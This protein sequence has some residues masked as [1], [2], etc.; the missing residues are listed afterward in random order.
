MKTL[1]T[2]AA[3]LA[4]GFGATGAAL[5]QDSLRLGTSSSGSVP[6]TI[7]V[8]MSRVIN[9]NAGINV[10]IEPVGGSIANIFALMNDQV[11]MAI[12]TALAAVDG[13]QG[14]APLPRAVPVCLIAQGQPSFRQLLVRRSANIDSL[15]ALRGKVWINAMAPNPDILLISNAMM[16]FAGLTTS[17]FRAV[18]M[19]ESGEAISGFETGTI[20]AVTLPAS[21]GAPTVARLMENRTID[22]Y[23]FGDDELEAIRSRLPRGMSLFTIPAGT[24]PNMAQDAQVFGMRTYLVANCNIDADLAY[25]ITAALLD[26]TA[27]LVTY[28]PTGRDWTV[29]NTV[30]NPVIPFHAGTV[31]YLEERGA[32]TEELAAFQEAETND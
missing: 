17:D 7:G 4:V 19:T 21:A 18:N 10:S 1:F 29:A 13:H 5:A 15:A 11:D 24:Y 30:D 31:R 26:N 20:D 8:G 2:A 22:F 23:Y 12:V 25:Q 16:E 27:D 14:N 6:Y 32:W 3:A 9:Q 28:H